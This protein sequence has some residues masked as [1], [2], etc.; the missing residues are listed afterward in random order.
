MNLS[1]IKSNVLATP[2]ITAEWVR[3]NFGD[4]R[5]K[6]TW[7]AALDRC[8]EF[9]AAVVDAAPVVIEQATEATQTAYAVLVPLMWGLLWFGCLTFHAGQA[10]TQW[11]HTAPAKA[12][13]S[14]AAILARYQDAR[15]SSTA[16]IG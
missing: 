4:L 12:S 13:D 1:Q 8:S 9:I 16:T 15:L 10:L 6:S 3:S 11:W 2:G 14:T 7:Q 5:F